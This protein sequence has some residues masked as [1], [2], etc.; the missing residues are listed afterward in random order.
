MG[1]A[2]AL[3][4]RTVFLLFSTGIHGFVTILLHTTNL[5]NDGIVTRAE[6]ETRPRCEMHPQSRI[7][8]N[9]QSLATVL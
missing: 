9:S 3:V 8:S 7:L 6:V 5:C 4:R 1:S 2:A